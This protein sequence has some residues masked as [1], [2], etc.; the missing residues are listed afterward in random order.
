MI[1][2]LGVKR[3]NGRQKARNPGL[4]RQKWIKA[5]ARGPQGLEH[6]RYCGP[7]PWTGASEAK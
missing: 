2:P 7:M 4:E 6:I 5:Q 3:D 1:D